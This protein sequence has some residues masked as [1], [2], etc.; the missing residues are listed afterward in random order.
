M[1][2]IKIISFALVALILFIVL[3]KTSKE[4]GIIL[5][6]IS[7]VV[8]LSLVA[9]KLD[10]VISL[11]NDLVTNAGINKEYLRVLLKVTGIAYIVELAKNICVDAGSSSLATKVELAGKI[12]IVALTIPIFTSVI[13]VIVNI[14]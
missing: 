9:I 10:D 3:E 4:F 13:S 6:I 14:V 8:I 12:S 7:S 1:D 5:T 2:I 11:L